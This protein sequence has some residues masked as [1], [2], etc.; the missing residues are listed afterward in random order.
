M[1]FRERKWLGIVHRVDNQTCVA[2]HVRVFGKSR[3]HGWH[4]YNY[5][6]IN[7]EWAL[8]RMWNLKLVAIHHF[9]PGKN[10]QWPGWYI[11]WAGW[12]K[13]HACRGHIW[14]WADKYS[15]KG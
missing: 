3:G 11:N 4:M 14:Q 12:R 15:V 9:G 10:T 7:P 13:C 8:H 5:N 2:G 6:Q 1:Q